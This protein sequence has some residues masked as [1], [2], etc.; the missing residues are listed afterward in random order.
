VSAALRL[1]DGAIHLPGIASA[2]SHAFQR[3]LRGRTQRRSTTA[4]SFWS[5]RG[6]MYELASKVSPETLYDLSHF[7]FVEL[8]LSGVTAVGEFHYVHHDASGAPYAD[9]TLLA[10]TVIRAA[11]DAG[12][13]ITLLRVVYERAGTGRP[14]EGAQRRFCDARIEDALGDV[15][16]LRARYAAEPRVRI[17]V[18][19]H[20]V[21]AVTKASLAAASDFARSEALPLHAHVSEQRREIRECLA[22]HGRRPVELLAD[23][24]ALGPLF[25]AVHATHLTPGEATLLGASRSF[26]C[27]CRTTERDLGDGAPDVAALV[28]AG[29]RLT[30]G[31]D[32][33]ASSCPFEEARA[34]ELDERTRVEARHVAVYAPALVEALTTDGYASLG[35]SLED[36][37]DHVVLDAKDPAL[38]GVSAPLVADGVV[39]AASAR[40]VRDVTIAGAPVVRAG[41]HAS[42]DAARARFERALDQ[43]G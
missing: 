40:A 28:R 32:S 26:A 31:V 9:R 15:A 4:G 41:R 42:F 34:I 39:F 24:G 17:G 13:R 38:V 5:W 6:L 14:P 25:S 29:A 19:P 8:A 12:L 16:S 22:E 7:A 23:V 35:W 10:D 2:H 1:E 21:R 20:S 36:C 11:L 43:L 3:A 37:D 27:L 33:H 30:I 18:A